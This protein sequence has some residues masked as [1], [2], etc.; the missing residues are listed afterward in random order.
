MALNSL[1]PRIQTTH[2]PIIVHNRWVDGDASCQGLDEVGCTAPSDPCVPALS[3]TANAPSIPESISS[4]GP[5][6]I[7]SG[8][9]PDMKNDD[10]MADEYPCLQSPNS[11]SPSPASSIIR[12][13]PDLVEDEDPLDLSAVPCPNRR[14]VHHNAPPTF[15]ELKQLYRAPMLT[16]KQRATPIATIAQVLLIVLQRVLIICITEMAIIIVVGVGLTCAVTLF[17]ILFC[18]I[19]MGPSA[20]N[21]ARFVGPVVGFIVWPVVRVIIVLVMECFKSRN[22]IIFFV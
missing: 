6:L 20:Y 8:A 17:T 2:M 14:I 15:E 10:A 13:A 12:V 22:G 18:G 7:P 9:G 5:P 11:S 3:P 21:V 1:N 4:L 19:F 16:E